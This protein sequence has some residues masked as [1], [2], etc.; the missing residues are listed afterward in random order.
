MNLAV[1]ARDAMPGG[2]TLSFDVRRIT[3]D[4]SFPHFNID[5]SPGR[6]IV[7]SI[8]DTGFGMEKD[9]VD[10]IFDPFFTTKATGQGTGLGLSTSI[11]IVRSHGGFINVYSEPGRGSRFSVYVPAEEGGIEEGDG[12]VATDYPKGIGEQILVV[13]DEEKILSVTRAT[14]EK[15][16]YRVLTARNGSEAVETFTEYKGR[17][18]AVL[19]DMAMPLMDGETAIREIRRIDPS[20]KIIAASG[21][22][23]DFASDPGSPGVEAFLSK[24]FTAE[25]LL[26]T[27][28]EVLAR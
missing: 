22:A 27:I 4:D 10:R 16:G 5:A 19:T 9:T 6:Y 21:L 18:D 11:S 25:V 24:P 13:D 20:A 26:K 7:V 2:G 14:L 1:N 15:F 17:I 12:D 28:A 8:E 23:S 3:V